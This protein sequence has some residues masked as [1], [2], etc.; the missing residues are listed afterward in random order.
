DKKHDEKLIARRIARLHLIKAIITSEFGDLQKCKEYFQKSYEYAVSSGN[1][2]LIAQT[3]AYRGYINMF[4]GNL[5]QA[6]ELVEESLKEAISI[7]SKSLLIDVYFVYGTIKLVIGKKNIA[8]EFFLKGI[9]LSNE[10][11]FRML[12]RGLYVHLGNAYKSLFRLDEALKYYKLVLGEIK[13]G[14]YL[15]LS[16]ISSINL[17]QNNI[18]EAQGTLQ[19]ALKDSKKTGEKRVRPY[20]LYNLVLSSLLLKDQDLAKEYL[21]EFEQLKSE[22]DFEHITLHYQTALVLILKESTR[23][24]DWIQAIEILEQ[25][26]VDEKLPKE[27]QIDVLYHL[28]EIRLKE[29]QV[30]ADQEVLAEVKKYIN[31]IQSFAEERRQFNLLANI[32]RLKSQ[33]ALVELDAEH[34]VDLLITAKTLAKEKHLDLIA[35]KIAEEQA[36][37]VEQ[38]NM[39]ARLKEQKAPLKETLKQVHLDNSAKQLANETILAVRNEK[40]KEVIEYRKLFALKM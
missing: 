17:I 22:E 16:N 40:T 3:R 15:V 31:Q 11:G 37:L 29:L 19:K 13:V 23:I 2:I 7:G 21:L 4:F 34:A 5:S 33:L 1:A 18:N 26:L 38:Q 20:I 32:Y 35:H 9:E 27:T 25:L 28:V 39:W 24:Q 14:H 6:N 10:I 8:I 30:T 36:K 12:L